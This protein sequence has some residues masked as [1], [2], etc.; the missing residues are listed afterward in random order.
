MFF[1][2]WLKIGWHM[3]EV[4]EPLWQKGRR[5]QQIHGSMIFII[6]RK[7]KEKRLVRRWGREGGDEREEEGIISIWTKKRL[8][9]NCLDFYRRSVKS[10]NTEEVS[11]RSSCVSVC[12]L[13]LWCTK[14][15]S[16][17]F[18]NVFT[19]GSQAKHHWGEGSSITYSRPDCSERGGMLYKN[20]PYRSSPSPGVSFVWWGHGV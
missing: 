9:I 19:A 3:I 10:S 11:Q 1:I 15:S 14:S 16:A 17:H 4:S 5:G 8:S 6:V 12:V 13:Q 2:G 18:A 20:L 7:E